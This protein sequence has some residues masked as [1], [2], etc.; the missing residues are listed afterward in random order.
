LIWQDIDTGGWFGMTENIR[1]NDI[2]IEIKRSNRRKTVEIILDRSG[3][4]VL[5]APDTLPYQKL[6]SLVKE[7]LIAIYLKQGKK[8]EEIHLALP[9][10]YVSGEGFYY[11]GRK[12]QLKIRKKTDYEDPISRLHFQDG[13]FVLDE[14]LVTS[15]RDVFISWYC[16]QAKEWINERINR[17]EE[18]VL[19]EPT[20]IEIRDLGYRWGSCTR[21]GKINFHWRIMLLPPE[22][23]DYLIL[24]ELIHLHEHN[25]S[26]EFYERLRRANPDYEKHEEWLRRNGDRYF[27]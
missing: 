5:F 26:K 27:L 4:P 1:I 7:K 2:T 24:H 16:T 19:V 23:I 13:R 25:H 15:G 10:E 6:L 3:N 9:K 11:L 8:M 20:A 21:R 12:Y 22:H 17:L 14:D 18:R